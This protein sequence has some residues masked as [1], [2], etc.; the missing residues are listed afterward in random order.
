[1]IM[2]LTQKEISANF[3]KNRKEN[4][5][6]PRCGKI[7]DRKGHY[8]SG[9]LDKVNQYRRESRKFYREH[10]ICPVCGKEKLIGSEKQCILCRQKLYEQRKPLTDEQ[11][12]RYSNRLKK[13][14]KSLYGERSEKGICTKCGKRIAEEGKKKCRICLNK[15]AEIHRRRRQDKINIKE[16]RKENHLCYY[17][18]GEIDVKNGNLCSK[19]LEKC[20]ENG[21]KSQS[22]NQYWEADNRIIFKNKGK[23]SL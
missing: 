17:C 20:R 2:A 10:G 14:Q 1:M 11:K 3:Y 7:L 5:L 4:G 16:Y 6:C 8:C 15:D 12:E 23:F 13:Q 19:C 22:T 18:G 21:T 9:C